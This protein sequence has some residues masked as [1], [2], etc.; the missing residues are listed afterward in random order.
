VGWWGTAKNALLAKDNTLDKMESEETDPTS[1]GPVG[2]ETVRTAGGGA[3]RT[4]KIDHAR[5]GRGRERRERSEP[6][7]W[8]EFDRSSSKLLKPR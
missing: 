3:M 4:R 2:P 5:D 7:L 8:E 1:S 6:Y